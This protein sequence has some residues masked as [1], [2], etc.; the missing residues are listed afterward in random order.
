MY[1][2]EIRMKTAVHECMAKTA[3][4]I[5]LHCVYIVYSHAH[6][7]GKGFGTAVQCYGYIHVLENEGNVS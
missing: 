3:S 4:S 1:D 2:V 5:D 7:Q 6:A